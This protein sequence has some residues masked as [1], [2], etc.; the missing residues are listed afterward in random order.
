M[1]P[2]VTALGLGLAG[3]ILF[4]VLR[5][6]LPWMLGAL[7][8]TTAAALFGRAI[9]VPSSLRTLMV[10]VLG[11]M[12]GSAFSPDIIAQAAKW[13]AAIAALAFYLSLSTALVFLWFRMVG[14]F[15]VVTAYFSAAP[16]GLT[17]MVELGDALGGDGRRIALVHSMR[18]LL[19]V[20]GIPIFFRFLEAGAAPPPL[21]EATARLW[22]D[23]AHIGL[24]DGLVLVGCGIV[25]WWGGEKLRLP[26]AALLGP[27]I[28][29]VVVH[30]SGLTG[31][32]PPSL[33][34]AIS[35]VVIGSAIGSRFR[36][37]RL[38]AIR[39]TLVVTIG[40][41]AL[42]LGITVGL[43]FALSGPLGIDWEPLV[44]AFAPGGLAEMALIALALGIGTAFVSMMHVFRILLI[45][46]VAPLVF[47]VLAP[48][49]RHMPLFHH[50][51]DPSADTG[52]DAP[53]GDGADDHEEGEREPEA[54]VAERRHG[55]QDRDDQPRQ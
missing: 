14:G 23:F 52:V 15:D 11:V 20:S 18:I 47:R 46:L 42:M 2:V 45:V 7:I 9:A 17:T 5:L 16:G 37:V 32:T 33:A 54:V 31:S 34:I 10:A 24:V 26:A 25:G 48:T 27:M 3:G 39:H 35:Q 36:G 30:L 29:S 19:I 6:P 12:L 41:T 13:P 22:Q 50:S 55:E 53:E 43:S 49:R 8:V 51:S 4:F 21:A 1:R 38:A 28:C 44:L 40:S